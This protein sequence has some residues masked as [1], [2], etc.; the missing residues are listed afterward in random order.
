MRI[1]KLKGLM[2]Y[3]GCGACKK[4]RISFV[5]NFTNKHKEVQL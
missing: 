1:K 2:S 5:S 4:L 3:K